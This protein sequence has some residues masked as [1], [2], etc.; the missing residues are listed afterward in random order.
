MSTIITAISPI[1]KVLLVGLVLGAGLPALFSLGIRTSSGTVSADGSV[2]A[3]TPAGRGVAAVC[4][5]VIGLVVVAAILVL[6]GV[7]PVLSMFG[8]S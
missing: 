6:A 3:P 4:F 7:K 1:W 8:L 2:T 5:V